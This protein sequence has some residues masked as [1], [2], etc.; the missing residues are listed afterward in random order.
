MYIYVH[1]IKNLFSTILKRDITIC[2]ENT[3]VK[4]IVIDH[5]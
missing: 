5:I 3:N 1:I 2:V 4:S